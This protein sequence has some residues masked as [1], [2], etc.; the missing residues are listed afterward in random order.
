[1]VLLTI[2]TDGKKHHLSG[3]TKTRSRIRVTPSDHKRRD[4][5]IA[6]SRGG[7]QLGG[8]PRG[9]LGGKRWDGNAG[10]QSTVRHLI[11]QGH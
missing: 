2:K 11:E 6:A 5:E 9:T 3:V 7:C 8:S 4:Y 1:M 10:K